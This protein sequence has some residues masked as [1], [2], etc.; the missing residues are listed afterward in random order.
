MTRSAAVV[1]GGTMGAGIAHVLLAAGDRVT[2]AE[3]GEERAAAAREAV[4]RS[5]RKAEER[6][7]LDG[8]A[9]E[10]LANLDVVPAIADLPR[11]AEL[12]VEAVPE[13]V[14]LKK[15]VLADIREACPDALLASNTSSLSVRQLG[16]D[17]IGMHFFNPVPVQALLELVVHDGLSADQVRAARAWG[18]SLGKS[19]IEVRDSPG[20]ATSRLGVVVGLEAIRMLEEGVASAADIDTGM[21]LGYGW[22][23]G[24]LRLTDLVGLD[25]RLSI[26]EHLTRELG[27][28][29]T[30]PDLL[31]NM[32]ARGELGRKTGR[33]FFDWT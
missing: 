4:A 13:N 3:A 29:F 14:P 19:V 23:M 26:A 33:G 21:R 10:L 9:D 8:T 15:Q 16:D 24:P 17:V 2:V 22:P 5:L 28:R 27:P 11:G 18:E 12:V 31:R 30:P 25:V 32:V 6:G 1:G 7:K 20:F